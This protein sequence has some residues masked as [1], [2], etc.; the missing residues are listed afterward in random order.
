MHRAPEAQHDGDLGSQLLRGAAVVTV[1]HEAVVAVGRREE[2]RALEVSTKVLDQRV[3]R[4]DPHCRST[5][6][7]GAL[8][9]P[10]DPVY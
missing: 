2:S 5:F 3:G 8:A 4:D 1:D 10:L 7:I 9:P 6:D